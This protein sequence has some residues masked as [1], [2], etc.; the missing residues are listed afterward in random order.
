MSKTVRIIL[1]IVFII[2]LAGISWAIIARKNTVKVTKD[3]TQNTDIKT[4]STAT[5]ATTV[6]VPKPVTD[7]SAEKTTPTKATPKKQTRTYVVYEEVWEESSAS[8][9]AQAGT[10]ANGNSYA[11]AHA[12]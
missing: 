6:E 11:E 5:P 7:T 9:W 4:S 8:A 2:F 12:E 10:D 3:S 1:I